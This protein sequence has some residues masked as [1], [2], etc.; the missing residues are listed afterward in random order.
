MSSKVCD[1]LGGDQV[2]LDCERK[3]IMFRQTWIDKKRKDRMLLDGEEL[4]AIAGMSLADAQM[5]RRDGVSSLTWINQKRILDEV[6]ENV[7]QEDRGEGDASM[8]VLYGRDG[9]RKASMRINAA[10][11]DEQNLERKCELE[12]IDYEGYAE[13][14]A[15]I[16]PAEIKIANVLFRRG[17]PWMHTIS[18]L[19]E[20]HHERK[21]ESEV[22]T[23]LKL[24]KRNV[25]WYVSEFV[26]NSILQIS[27][28]PEA[29]MRDLA[30]EI[31][32]RRHEIYNML[33]EQEIMKEFPRGTGRSIVKA[34]WVALG[35]LARTDERRPD[36][37]KL[38]SAIEERKLPNVLPSIN[39]HFKGEAILGA[40]SQVEDDIWEN[41]EDVA[42]E[43]S[44]GEESDGTLPTG[45]A[46]GG[47]GDLIGAE[48]AAS[49]D[50]R[51]DQQPGAEASIPGIR[52]FLLAAMRRICRL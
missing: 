29:N 32:V 40:R 20:S 25:A 51:P 15:D 33:D 45:G 3:E 28:D 5:V 41:T 34:L 9:E 24:L 39:A 49:T 22:L 17:V 37:Q 27:R 8:V 42:G 21:L 44:F 19:G 46:R 26:F 10:G 11:R 1:T 4:K 38:L 35:N 7:A 52:N 36:E 48:S 30:L 13:L 50:G 47:A 6:N 2:G 14:N 16:H 18:V 31:I 43:E 23:E 12:N